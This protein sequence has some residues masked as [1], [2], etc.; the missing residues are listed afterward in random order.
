MGKTACAS[1]VLRPIHR[2]HYAEE[3]ESRQTT[4]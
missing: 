2:S 1:I 4:G 3:T